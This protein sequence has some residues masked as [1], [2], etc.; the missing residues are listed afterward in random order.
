MIGSGI[1]FSGNPVEASSVMTDPVTI[2]LIGAFTTVIVSVVNVVFAV[3]NNK[4][5]ER[6]EHHLV[7]L[8]EQ[9]NGMQ[10]QLVAVT[11]KAAFAEGVKAG[12][13]SKK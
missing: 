11:S 10:A 7:A 5:G 4:R 2:S 6:N 8:K 1:R 12:E 13:D 9:T 3:I